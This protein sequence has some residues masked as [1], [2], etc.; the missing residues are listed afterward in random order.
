MYFPLI[1]KNL[2]PSLKRQLAESFD[3]C[4]CTILNY[5][6]TYSI[7][8]KKLVSQDDQSDGLRVRNP[9]LWEL[10]GHNNLTATA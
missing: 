4:P 8:D 2:E 1:A 7:V 6:S 9:S 3:M 10:S 5:A